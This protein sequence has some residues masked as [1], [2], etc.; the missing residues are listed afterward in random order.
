[1]RYCA[2]SFWGEKDVH[3]HSRRDCHANLRRIDVADR[4]GAALAARARCA[5]R[6]ARCGSTAADGSEGVSKAPNPWRS[7]TNGG[8]DDRPGVDACR[9]SDNGAL[10]CAPDRRGAGVKVLGVALTE[11][12]FGGLGPATRLCRILWRRLGQACAG[13]HRAANLHTIAFAGPWIPAR[14]R[15]DVACEGGGCRRRH[16][17]PRWRGFGKRSQRLAQGRA[18]WLRVLSPRFR[19][20]RIC[21][22]RSA[23]VEVGA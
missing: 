21:R 19:Q 22:L 10:A 15:D 2:R 14:G 4:Q 18:R 13:V 20:M 6:P 5:A 17:R 16:I 3:L 7:V 11:V 23:I 9:S 8:A 1:M 12:V